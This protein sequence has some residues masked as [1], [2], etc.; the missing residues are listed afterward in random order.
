MSTT[1]LAE[2]HPLSNGATPWIF[3]ENEH[4][5]NSKEKQRTELKSSGMFEDEMQWGICLYDTKGTVY[6]YDVYLPLHLKKKSNG[7]DGVQTM[8]IIVED[9]NLLV[10]SG[11][12]EKN[13]RWKDLKNQR[14]IQKVLDNHVALICLQYEIMK[15]WNSA[16]PYLCIFASV[17]RCTEE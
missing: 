16:T 9:Y 1:P 11:W 4:R 5:D 10:G 8:W 2:K 17:H 13:L 12:S 3:V 7:R 15:V 6:S 14:W